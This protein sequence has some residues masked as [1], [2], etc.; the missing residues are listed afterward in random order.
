MPDDQIETLDLAP[1][2]EAAEREQQRLEE[3]TNELRRAVMEAS[4][5]PE[6][7]RGDAGSAAE[8]VLDLETLIIQYADAMSQGRLSEAEEFAALI[9]RSPA[10]ADA[11]IQRISSDE[12]PPRRSRERPAARPD[13][14]PETAQPVLSGAWRPIAVTAGRRASDTSGR[15]LLPSFVRRTR[16]RGYTRVDV[17]L[18]KRRPS[19]CSSAPRQ[20]TVPSLIPRL[21]TRP[22]YP[23]A[24]GPC[25]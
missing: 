10:S 6:E 9:R 11:V 17:G 2:D 3:E 5:L 16:R 22:A 24:S 21:P 8:P 18:P 25:A 12:I 13:R 15:K 14:L 7:P 1:I 20:A 23:V 4:S 19:P